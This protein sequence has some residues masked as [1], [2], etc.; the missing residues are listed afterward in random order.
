MSSFAEAF[1]P[2]SPEALSRSAA[3]AVAQSVQSS[4]WRRL[5]RAGIPKPG[6]VAWAMVKAGQT[7]RSNVGSHRS[8]SMLSAEDLELLSEL[9][10]QAG[11]RLGS[12]KGQAH[13]A[14]CTE[15]VAVLREIRESKAPRAPS[16]PSPFPAVPLAP[17][18]D[19]A[20]AFVL[21]Q[22]SL[23]RDPT[24]EELAEAERC[25]PSA[26]RRA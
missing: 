9:A 12:T 11:R 13:Q 24:P 16:Q 2:E 6:T 3:A 21:W 17:G 20:M 19:A 23:G 10:E 5:Q 22:S 4:L 26:A 25:W 8:L 7:G 14:L 1:G 15:I 18:P